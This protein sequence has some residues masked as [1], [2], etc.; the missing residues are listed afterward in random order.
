MDGWKRSG[1]RNAGTGAHKRAG[2]G[3]HI[4]CH[5]SRPREEGEGGGVDKTHVYFVNT[6]DTELER[7]RPDARKWATMIGRLEGLPFHPRVFGER[8][9]S[10]RV[11]VYG[12]CGGPGCGSLR[13]CVSRAGLRGSFL[14]FLGPPGTSWMDSSCQGFQ[15]R[16]KIGKARSV[17]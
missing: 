8:T 10:E 2:G 5:S 16:C 3:Q 14:D 9:F 13:C 11:V 15:T 17:E 12:N 4:R 7:F 6:S 1:P